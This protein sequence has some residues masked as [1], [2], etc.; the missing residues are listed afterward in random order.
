MYRGKAWVS[1]HVTQLLSSIFSFFV[2]LICKI[3]RSVTGAARALPTMCCRTTWRPTSN[4]TPPR[5]TCSG[6]PQRSFRACQ[7]I[8]QTFMFQNGPCNDM[9]VGLCLQ[10]GNLKPL[11]SCLES[12]NLFQT[13][14]LRLEPHIRARAWILA[15]QPRPDRPPPLLR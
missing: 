8:W 9:S 10:N 5:P 3:S 7:N 14:R 12:L 1:P 13:A 6:G 4:L 11:K 15:C 2:M